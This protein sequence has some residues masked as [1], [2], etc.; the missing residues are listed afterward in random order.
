[1]TSSAASRR[2]LPFSVTAIFCLKMSC[3]TAPTV[4][5]PF[6][7]PFG[8]PLLPEANCVAFGAGHSRRRNRRSESSPISHGRAPRRSWSRCAS[9]APETSPSDH[10]PHCRVTIGRQRR[11]NAG[12]Y[13]CRFRRASSGDVLETASVASEHRLKFCH[14]L[15]SQDGDIDVAGFIFD[16]DGDAR[17][18]FRRQNGRSRT[19]KLIEHDVAPRGAIEQRVG[20]Q[21]DRFDAWDERRALPC[22]S[23]PNVLMP[24]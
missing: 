15:P 20:D 2:V 5:L 22:D 14:A 7:R 17:D 10:P 24:A 12:R 18:F 19:H 13:T 11:S 3:R 23:W 21:R 6:G 16:A 4:R 8:L 9:S 1:M